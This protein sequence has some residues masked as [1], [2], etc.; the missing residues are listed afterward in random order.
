MYYSTDI[1]RLNLLIRILENKDNFIIYTLSHTPK[2]ALACTYKVTWIIRYT[3]IISTLM[4]SPNVSM[5]HRLYCIYSSQ[6]HFGHSTELIRKPSV[7]EALSK[8]HSFMCNSKIITYHAQMQVRG[9]CV[10]HK[11]CVAGLCISTH[12]AR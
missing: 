5:I 12:I 3:L 4:N 8:Q 10:F 11:C 9:C 6:Q 2:C 1:H 7:I